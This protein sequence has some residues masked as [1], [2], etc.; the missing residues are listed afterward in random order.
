MVTGSWF[1]HAHTEQAA[2]AGVAMLG[3][4]YSLN[5]G[6]DYNSSVIGDVQFTDMSQSF[7]Y[8][9]DYDTTAASELAA[10]TVGHIPPISSDENLQ[11]F[12]MVKWPLRS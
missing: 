2:Q 7:A 9:I 1:I 6:V 11:I 12:S 5:N 4:T 3:L 8:N 10:H